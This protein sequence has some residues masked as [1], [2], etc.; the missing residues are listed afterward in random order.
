MEIGQ[1][2]EDFIA[3]QYATERYACRPVVREGWLMRSK[4]HP[5]ALATPDYW[6]QH[7]E[8]GWIPLEV[9]NVG[10]WKRGEWEDGPPERFRWQGVQQCLVTKKPAASFVAL[11]GGGELVWCDVVPEK[12]EFDRLT[13]RGEWFW[14]CVQDDV[15]PEIDDHPDIART[16]FEMYPEDDKST[17][18]L[19]DLEQI[20]EQL[21]C[22]KEDRKRAEQTITGLENILRKHIGSA[23]F[24]ELP[25][26]VRYSN[27][28]QTKR[29]YVS[30]KTSFR[31][32]RR[33]E[34]K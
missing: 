19:H 28:L 3:S 8:Y 16:L 25:N 5:W 17:V 13:E 34:A 20:D 14:R 32:L 4:E 2:I 11:I 22:A 18:T 30:P 24:G 7:V 23:T 26:G 6:A 29:E 10:Q 12:D 15:E 27:K 1:K 33:H 9:K 31:V 21:L